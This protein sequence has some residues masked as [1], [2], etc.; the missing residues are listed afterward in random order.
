M[1]GP[2]NGDTSRQSNTPS[3]V[4][5]I[6]APPIYI[7]FVIQFFVCVVAALVSFFLFGRV[8]AYSMLLGGFVSIVPN[9]Y[10]AWKAFRYR[11]AR[12]TPLI[13]KSFYAG[14]TGKLVMTGLLF[15]LVFA[16]VRPLDEL[17]VIVSFILTLVVGLAAAGWISVTWPR[18]QARRQSGTR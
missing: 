9:G 16:G 5:N 14:E 12:N 15:A 17:A 2:G 1:D 13:V 11:G 4:T 6:K 8:T 10:F 7:A 18:R 3:A